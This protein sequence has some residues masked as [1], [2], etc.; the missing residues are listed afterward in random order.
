[1]AEQ[2]KN[3]F[4]R[5]IRLSLL[6]LARQIEHASSADKLKGFC[7]TTAEPQKCFIEYIK[8]RT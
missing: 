3:D 8:K 4:V 6:D 2:E 1:M 5:S 7:G